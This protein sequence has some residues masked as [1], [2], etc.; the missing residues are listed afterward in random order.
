M[1][2]ESCNVIGG[3]TADHTQWMV[4]VSDATLPCFLNV[5]LNAKKTKQKQKQDINW[6][7]PEILMIK[8]PHNLIEQDAQLVTPKQ[9]WLSQM[10]ISINKI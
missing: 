2:K 6:F 9:K 10:I 4:E 5:Y 1:I 8:E 3:G 7:F